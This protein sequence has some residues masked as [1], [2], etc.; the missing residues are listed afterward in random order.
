MQANAPS[1]SQA[2]GP[3]RLGPLLHALDIFPLIFIWAPF[4]WTGLVWFVLPS[5]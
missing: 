5:Q 3:G 2:T 4:F 1:A